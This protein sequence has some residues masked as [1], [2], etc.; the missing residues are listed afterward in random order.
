M[1]GEVTVMIHNSYFERAEQFKCLGTNL[2]NK[3]S[4]QEKIMS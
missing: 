4:S 2:T 1:Q 3:N